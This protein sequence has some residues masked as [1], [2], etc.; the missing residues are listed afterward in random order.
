[1]KAITRRK[2]AIRFLIRP[3]DFYLETREDELSLHE[4]TNKNLEAVSKNKGHT[5]SA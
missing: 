3:L 2:Y 4:S 5:S 1:M